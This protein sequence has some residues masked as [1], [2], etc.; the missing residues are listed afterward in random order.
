MALDGLLNY[1][2]RWIIR[3]GL[4]LLRSRSNRDN[5]GRKLIMSELDAFDRIPVSLHEATLD[6]TRFGTIELDRHGRFVVIR[7]P[8]RDFSSTLFGRGASTP[9]FVRIER[10]A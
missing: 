5:E 6:H 1:Y 2:S 3:R 7:D 4:I 9:P 10:G 8:T